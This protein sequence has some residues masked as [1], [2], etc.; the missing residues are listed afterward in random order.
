[1]RHLAS[2]RPFAYAPPLSAFAAVTARRADL[3][4]PR[5]CSGGALVMYPMGVGLNGQPFLGMDPSAP[6]TWV[7]PYNPQP[8]M[9]ARFNFDGAAAQAYTP[10]GGTW[11]NE[12]RDRVDVPRRRKRGGSR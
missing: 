3:Q 12:M 6:S 8:G 11:R 1:M 7:R 4:G 9:V 2:T 5:P 10:M